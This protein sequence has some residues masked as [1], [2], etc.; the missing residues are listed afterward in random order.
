MRSLIVALMLCLQTVP[1]EKQDFPRELKITFEAANSI[2]LVEGEPD[3]II[4]FLDSMNAI[5]SPDWKT[6]ESKF[7]IDARKRRLNNIRL[8]Y[9]WKKLR[10][11]IFNPADVSLFEKAMNQWHHEKGK[12]VWITNP[13]P[14]LR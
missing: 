7:W 5:V 13:T 6:D 4:E 8:I 9:K 11:G 2:A 1:N 10:C 3:D 12:H 14:V